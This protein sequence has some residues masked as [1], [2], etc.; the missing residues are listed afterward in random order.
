[1]VFELVSIGVLIAEEDS[2]RS[3]MQLEE[4]EDNEG[5][6][7]LESVKSDEVIRIN[8]EESKARRIS[9]E[10]FSCQ[11]RNLKIKIPLTNPSRTFSAISYLIKED[12]INQNSKKCGQ[13]GNKL[14]ISKSKLNH[15]EKMIK[16]ALMELYKGL[17]YL[18]TYRNLN[19]LAF[20]K[21][22]KKFDKVK[23]F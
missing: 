6:T 20:M 5:E 2:V 18:K 8:G 21:I 3:R 11:G 10:V 19:M 23:Q 7:S 4:S 15:A 17:N 14:R 12:L 16:G 13:D 22:L 9:G 1:M